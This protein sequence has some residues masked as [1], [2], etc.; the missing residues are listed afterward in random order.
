MM[1]EKPTMAELFVSVARA[2]RPGHKAKKMIA[3][4]VN[5]APVV[6]LGWP[7]DGMVLSSS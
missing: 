7:V 5:S 6:N 1:L 4:P 3:T 2:E